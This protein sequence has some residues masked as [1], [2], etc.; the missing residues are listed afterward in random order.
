MCWRI[1]FVKRSCTHFPASSI[2]RAMLSRCLFWLCSRSMMRHPT[3]F[4]GPPSSLAM[5]LVGEWKSKCSADD[6]KSDIDRPLRHCPHQARVRRQGFG[7]VL[8]W[9][10]QLRLN[11]VSHV[12]KTRQ[13]RRVALRMDSR[14]QRC[15]RK[16]GR[17]R[18]CHVEPKSL[19]VLFRWLARRVH[20]DPWSRQ[21]PQ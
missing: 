16:C 5:P 13:R 1:T 11:A 21:P 12:S 10:Q 14:L 8:K 15:S 18:F 3:S 20:T 17:P 2:L 6:A 19:S 9:L 7:L 4:V